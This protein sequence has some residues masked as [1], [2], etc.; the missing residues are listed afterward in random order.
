MKIWS[1]HLLDNLSNCLMNLKNSGDST[2]FERMTSAMPVQCSNQLSY[3][4]TRLRA[5][6]FCWAHVF[7]W[8]EFNLISVKAI[9]GLCWLSCLHS[10]IETISDCLMPTN[11]GSCPLRS[12]IVLG[13]LTDRRWVC[14]IGVHVRSCTWFAGDLLGAFSYTVFC[15]FCLFLSFLTHFW[16]KKKKGRNTNKLF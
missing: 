4:V 9:K 15:C 7:P 16:K 2:G 3:E 8:K 10:T 6:Q 14:I 13:H 12:Q 1:S 11:S 5:G